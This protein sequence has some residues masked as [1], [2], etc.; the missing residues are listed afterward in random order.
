MVYK[1]FCDKCGKTPARDRYAYPHNFCTDLCEKHE[2]EFDSNLEQIQ[3][4]NES[5]TKE[6]IAKWKPK[7]VEHDPKNSSKR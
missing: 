6:F 5:L 7:E 1:L 4:T 3:Q 2:K